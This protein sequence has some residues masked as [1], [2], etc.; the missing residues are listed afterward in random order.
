M[1]V[2]YEK[3]Q[4]GNWGFLT[5]LKSLQVF[6]R[7][8]ACRKDVA[9]DI[10]PKC[11]DEINDERWAHGE[12]WDVNEPGP[13]TGSGDTHSLADR[14]AHSKNLPLDEVFKLVHTSKLVRIFVK[15]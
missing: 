2:R 4:L 12:E 3:Y 7:I 1:V 8:P 11:K 9:L 6:K 15:K 5:G 13:D 14:C 10:H